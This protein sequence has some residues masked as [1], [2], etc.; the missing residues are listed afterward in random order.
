MRRHTAAEANAVTVSPPQTIR[1][2]L[3]CGAVLCP[4]NAHGRYVVDQ[5]QCLGI[6]QT[7]EVLKMGMPTRVTYTE[8]KEVR[9]PW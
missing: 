1:S 7:C 4:A 9:Y 3:I 2:V 8:L 5:L 6:L